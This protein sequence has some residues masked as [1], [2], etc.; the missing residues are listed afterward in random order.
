MLRKMAFVRYFLLAGLFLSIIFALTSMWYKIQFWNF[1]FT[2]QKGTPVWTIEAHLNFKPLANEN[3]RIQ[4]AKPSKSKSFKVLDETIV[5]KDYEVEEA[6][7]YVKLTSQPKKTEQNV[8]YRLLIYDKTKNDDFEKDKN[9]L[10]IEAPLFDDEKML[11][12]R[13]F[14]ETAKA[15]QMEEYNTI[16]KIIWLLNTDQ[17]NEAFITL[18]PQRKNLR[19]LALLVK[20]LLAIEKIPARLVR[21]IQ[22]V[23]GK[24]ALVADVMLEVYDAENEIWVTY[25]IETAQKG[26]PEN[27]IAFQRGNASL[28]DVEG[29]TDSVIKYSVLKSINS[30]FKMAYHRAKNIKQETMFNFSI[31]NLPIAEQNALKWLMIFPLAI[32]IVVILRNVVGIKTMGTFTPMLI[33]MALVQT[34]FV[35]GLICFSLIVGV[36]LCIRTLLSKLNLLLVPRISAVVVFVILIIQG[37][38]IIGYQYDLKTATAALFFP[39]IIMA[40]IIERA[41]IIWEEEGLKNAV[42]E[43]ISSVFVAIITYFVIMN[44]L[45]RHIMFVFNE[46]NI[47]ILFIIMLLGIYTGYR[48]SELKRFAPLVKEGVKK[49]VTPHKKT[50]RKGK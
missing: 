23:E 17:S 13:Q 24:K 32:L 7:N 38:A 42:K 1:S 50:K 3:I 20:D 21:G 12:A 4:F 22:L 35:P 48:L 37:L 45:I 30:S 6:E 39:I 36:G 2:P 14:I 16:Q 18:L 10:K 31:Y 19:E 11:I 28:V 26:V 40:W 5:A 43:V 27:F 34:G 33:S 25:N 8:Y 46:L 41:S 47:V 49:K 15:E 44:D 9:N 29:G